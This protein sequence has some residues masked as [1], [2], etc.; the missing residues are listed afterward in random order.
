MNQNDLFPDDTNLICRFASYMEGYS[1]DSD[2]SETFDQEAPQESPKRGGVATI[3][4]VTKYSGR[5]PDQTPAIVTYHPQ[6]APVRSSVPARPQRGRVFR[7]FLHR[8]GLT[9]NSQG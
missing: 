2:R 1:S 9:S 6:Q 3:G 8:V 7:N 4:N 5:Q